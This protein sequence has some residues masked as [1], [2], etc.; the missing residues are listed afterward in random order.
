METSAKDRLEVTT[1]LEEEEEAIHLAEV[2]EAILQAEEA[3]DR[4]LRPTS[5]STRTSWL[6]SQQ[7]YEL[8]YHKMNR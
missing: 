8:S 6:P 5:H 1:L 7:Q 2:E 3:M 4:N